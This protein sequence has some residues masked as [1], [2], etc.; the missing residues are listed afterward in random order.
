MSGKTR[1][2][3]QTALISALTLVT[4]YFSS[5][6]PTGKIGLVA[7]A[8]V[9]TAAA[10]VEA[11]I[12]CG[13]YVYIVCFALGMLLIPDRSAVILYALFFGYYPVAKSIIE[14]IRGTVLQWV[15]KLLVFNAALSAGWFLMRALILGATEF[16]YGAVILYVGGNILFIMFD[17]GFSKLIWLYIS[18]ISKFT[19]KRN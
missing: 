7:L 18:R 12:R 13:L 17:Y 5:V 2:V 8:C 11:G 19:G 3:T 9:F 4:L 14:R 1:L 10:V 6:W 16:K 15:L